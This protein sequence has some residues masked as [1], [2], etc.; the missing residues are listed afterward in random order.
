[1]PIKDW[2]S[3]YRVTAVVEDGSVGV[4]KFA[5][6]VRQHLPSEDI[7]FVISQEDA[8]FPEEVLRALRAFE[9]FTAYLFKT[10]IEEP[11]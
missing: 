5:A 6:V 4:T 10:S 3:L 11:F 1:M 8:P 7:T 2:G 9:E